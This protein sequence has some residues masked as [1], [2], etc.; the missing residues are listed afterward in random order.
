VRAAAGHQDDARSRKHRLRHPRQPPPRLLVAEAQLPATAAAAGVHR[1]VLCHDRQ[2]AVA[3]RGQADALVAKQLRA[4][5]P[6]RPLLV[7]QGAQSQLAVTAVAPGI[8]LTSARNNPFLERTPLNDCLNTDTPRRS[9]WP[10]LL[11]HDRHWIGFCSALCP[12]FIVVGN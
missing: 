1:T 6:G 4:S 3:C 8:Q 9:L 10:A 5:R 7:P 2:V 11:S 12:L